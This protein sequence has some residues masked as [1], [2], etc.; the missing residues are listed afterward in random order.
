MKK[1]IITSSIAALSATLALAQAHEPASSKAYIRAGV[2]YAFPHAGN[3]YL[4]TQSGSF[5]SA[6]NVYE[7]YSLGA[8]A[9]INVAGGFWLFKNIGLELGVHAGIAPKKFVSKYSNPNETAEA[10]LYARMPVYLIPSL[11]LQTGGEKANVYTRLGVV[12]NVTG[13]LTEE[14]A[15]NS[16]KW[17]KEYRMR[18]GIGFQGALGVSLPMGKSVCFFAEVNGISMSQY[19]KKTELVM[20][21]DNGIDVLPNLDMAD[22]VTEYSDQVS[23]TYTT[24]NPDPDKPTQ[25]GTYSLPFSNVGFSAG[26]MIKL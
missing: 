9:H 10:K 2:G 16:L 11:V 18:T 23:I 26:V 22:K 3:S 12:V 6:S 17:E 20:V 5:L 1:I 14:Y 8:G 19:L 24:A 15:S 25:A 21:R 4:K 7:K 13:K